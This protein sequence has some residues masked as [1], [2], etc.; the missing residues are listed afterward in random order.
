MPESCPIELV[1][2]IDDA[3]AVREIR[4]R[5]VESHAAVDWS[6]RERTELTSPSPSSLPRLV[7]MDLETMD[8]AGEDGPAGLGDVPFIVVAANG[9]P[10]D[11]MKAFASGASDFFSTLPEP[12]EFQSRLR[13]HALAHADDVRNRRSSQNAVQISDQ[14]RSRNAELQELNSM[15]RQSIDALRDKVDTQGVRLQS[16]GNVGIELNEIRDLDILMQHVL[17]EA[18]H[19]VRAEAGAILTRDGDDLVVRFVQNDAHLQSGRSFVDLAGG[20]RVPISHGSI[21]GRV[22]ITG[23]YVNVEDVYKIPDDAGYHFLSSYDERTGYRTKAMLAYP[24]KSPNGEPL[25][26]LQL[27]NPT[28]P[29]DQPKARFDTEDVG[30]IRNLASIASVALER[31]RIT[32]S[33]IERMIA[34]AEIHDPKETGAHVKRV[35]GYSRVLFEGWA[36]RRGMPQIEMERQRDR[37]SIAAMLHDVGKIGIPDSILK[38]PGRLDSSEFA[39]MQ[40]HTLIGARLFEHTHADFDELARTVALHHH[41]R[42]DGGGYPGALDPDE[43]FQPPAEPIRQGLVGD[44]IPVEARIVGLADVYDALCSARSYKEAWPEERVL[45]EIQGLSG[46]H[47]DPELVEIFLEELDRIRAVRDTHPRKF[48]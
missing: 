17:T 3:A 22:S 14:L 31:A 28:T 10:Q 27:A 38:K 40:M 13:R 26:V 18:R 36:K 25:G 7:L 42:W 44:E 16:I 1:V 37:L 48:Q 21:S 43:V 32:R 46:T 6:V 19:L 11:M 5:L 8:E 35:A 45:E 30:L 34:M 33:L 41:E 9:S 4:S 20:F 23:E 29:D 39:R 12:L 47:F 24:L 15:F 2:A